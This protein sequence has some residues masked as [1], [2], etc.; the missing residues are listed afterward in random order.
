MTLRGEKVFL[1]ALEPSDLDF[2]Y[3]IENDESIWE[4]S[5]TSTPYSRFV[6]KQYLANSHRDIYDVKQLRLVICSITDNATI[7]LID[8]FDFDPKNKRV[9]LGVI[10]KEEINRGKG[11][12]Q[13]AI[14]LCL[15]YV[16]SHLALHQVF[17]NIAEDNY[18]SI[19]LFE[20]VGFVMCGKKKDWLFLGGHYKTELLYQYIY[21]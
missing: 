3:A 15:E 20:K 9:G 11:F 19:Q 13:E 12:A 2:L 16:K 21:E 1:R 7:G 14:R 18:P 17:A 4:I 6:L 10:I 5:N 8:L